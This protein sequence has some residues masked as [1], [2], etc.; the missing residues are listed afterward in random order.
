VVVWG[1]S[2]IVGMFGIGWLNVGS[3]ISPSHMEHFPLWFRIDVMYSY[4]LRWFARCS[5]SSGTVK[6]GK[7]D[8]GWLWRVF[9][10][11]D[12]TWCLVCPSLVSFATDH[13]AGFVFGRGGCCVGGVVRWLGF[14][15]G[16]V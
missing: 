16:H 11:D 6:V 7:G 9:A 12:P 4:C 13:L 15:N 2:D 5:A 14:G 1:G 10:S 3:G 8:T